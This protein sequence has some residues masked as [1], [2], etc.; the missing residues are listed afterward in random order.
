MI[1]QKFLKHQI[2]DG[3][4]VQSIAA[5][6]LKDASRGLEIAVLNDLDYPFITRISEVPPARTK[7]MTAGDII[8]V[9][10]QVDNTLDLKDVSDDLDS[11]TLGADILLQAD[12]SAL[13]LASGG[14]FQANTYLDLQ[15][16]SGVDTLIQDLLHRLM[17]SPGS[18]P[19]HPSYGSKFLLIV[20]QKNN[21]E[22][23][24]KAVIELC[25]TFRCDPRVKDVY[26]VKLSNVPTGLAIECTVSTA[27]L[28]FTIKHFVKE[29]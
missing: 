16:A 10:I 14:E 11:V 20:G 24:Q 28:E 19:Y 21:T 4:S 15:L 27:D 26:N 3:E 5:K 9:P 17:T 18:L 2:V 23:R 1:L 13:S 7:T 29:A 12:L 22:W 25:R 6:Y 8:L